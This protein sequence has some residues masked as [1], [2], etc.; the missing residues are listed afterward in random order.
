MINQNDTTQI[1]H[2]IR[3]F[4]AQNMLFS[5]DGFHY[6]DD[7]SFLQQGIIDSLGVMQLVEFSQKELK[8]SIEQDEI[9][10]ENFDS[11]NKLAALVRRK[12]PANPQGKC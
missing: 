10:P 2:R 5:E 9:T 6:S 1:E 3:M 4:I 7:D 11:V 12:L 8:V